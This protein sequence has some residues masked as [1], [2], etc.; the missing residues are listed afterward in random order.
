VKAVPASAR[1]LGA[2]RR[3]RLARPGG[4]T[5]AG[6]AANTEPLTVTMSARR[7]PERLCGFMKVRPGVCSDRPSVL[8]EQAWVRKSSTSHSKMH[9]EASP[10]T[11]NELEEL[12]Y[13]KISVSPRYGG[14]LRHIFFGRQ[15][16]G[17]RMCSVS[18]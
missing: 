14:G 2:A 7:R 13:G 10:L 15:R 3:R 8:Y 4:A 16:V 12:R 11:P 18:L 17:W 6:Q 5:R 9:S 1:P